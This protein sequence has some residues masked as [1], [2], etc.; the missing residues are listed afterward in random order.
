[1]IAVEGAGE[2]LPHFSWCLMSEGNAWADRRWHSQT[3]L[4]FRGRSR[5]G[6]HLGRGRAE[7]A[8]TGHVA[9]WS[10]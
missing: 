8:T 3:V 6:C 7:C 5:D 2:L 10:L 1:M 4:I 9:S